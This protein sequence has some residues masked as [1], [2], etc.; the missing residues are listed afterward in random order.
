MRAKTTWIF[1]G[2]GANARIV[3][4][5][6]PG[7]GLE[8]D[9]KRR[10]HDDQH[11]TREL[12]TDRPASRGGVSG[13]ERH[14]VA[15]RA[16]WHRMEKRDFARRMAEML[17]AAAAKGEFD[18]LVLVSPASTLGALRELLGGAAR[19]RV[20]A[21]LAKDLTKIPDHELPGHLGDVIAL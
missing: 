5:H 11:R 15:P 1:I 2:D 13:E 7:K 3:V 6:G 19:K 18:R 12:G 4:N 21:T 17:D 16:D 14:G 9:A 8:A 10:F 20:S